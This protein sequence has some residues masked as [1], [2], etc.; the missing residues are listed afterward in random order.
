MEEASRE[1]YERIRNMSIAER[2]KRAMLAEVI[3]DRI[4]SMY[5]DLEGLVAKDGSVEKENRDKVT[6]LAIQIK[7]SQKQY[8]TL[9]T[10]EPSSMLDMMEGDR[11]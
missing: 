11:E 7:A 2:T 8:R 1:G 6:E 10:G 4:F 3:E 9:V 5:D